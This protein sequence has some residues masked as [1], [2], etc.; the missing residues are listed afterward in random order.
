MDPAWWALER[1]WFFFSCSFFLP[2]NL[3]WLFSEGASLPFQFSQRP[4]GG[5]VVLALWLRSRALKQGPRGS[6]TWHCVD[7]YLGGVVLRW[8]CGAGAALVRETTD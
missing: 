4:G 1:G 7:R 6:A 5:D 3:P 2:A 8:F